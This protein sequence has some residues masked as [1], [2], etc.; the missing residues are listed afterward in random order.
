M[1]LDQ[2]LNELQLEKMQLMKDAI[3]HP[4]DVTR[5][6]IAAMDTIIDR[7]R[8][9]KRAQLKVRLKLPFED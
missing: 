2:L 8:H 3:A 9:K 5:G 6:Q 1:T 7:I 4:S